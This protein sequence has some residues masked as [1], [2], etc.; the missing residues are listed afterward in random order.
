MAKWFITAI[1]LCTCCLSAPAQIEKIDTDRPDQ[2]ESAFTVPKNWLQQELGFVKEKRSGYLQTLYIWT[3]P[4]LLTRIGLSERLELRMIN[5]YE[6]WGNNSRLFRD[7]LGLLPLQLGLKVNLVKAKGIIPQ[8]SFIVH[9]GFNKLASEFARGS[10]FFAPNFRFTL[11]NSIT[12]NFAIGY[13]IGAEWE[14]TSEKP[15]WVYTFAPGY[16]I[17]DKWYAYIELFGGFTKN[18]KPEHNFDAGIAYNINDN[19]KADASAGV[20]LSKNA[21]DN[22]VSV[23]IS[24][25]FKIKKQKD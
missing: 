7:T 1:L 14:N 4:T 8:I 16:N 24:W 17:S 22:Y 3:L 9:T 10:S 21:P 20:G 5:E 25:R 13:N 15:V 19:L 11:Q 12:E 6:R 23:G 18:E 2:T